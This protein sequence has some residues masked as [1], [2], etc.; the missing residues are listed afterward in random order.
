M[1]DGAEKLYVPTLIEL[2]ALLLGCGA[3]SV[4]LNC[5]MRVENPKQFYSENEMTRS[6]FC[7]PQTQQHNSYLIMYVCHH[8]MS[9]LQFLLRDQFYLVELGK[10]SSFI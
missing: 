4:G 8:V 9:L 1:I 3:V 7:V 2:N 6:H 10:K 5:F